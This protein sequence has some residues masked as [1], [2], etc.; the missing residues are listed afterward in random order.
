MSLQV[1]RGQQP[2][3]QENV[4]PDFYDLGASGVGSLLNV[5]AAPQ[6]KDI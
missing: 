2:G 6:S 4:K 1:T 3:G 5:E